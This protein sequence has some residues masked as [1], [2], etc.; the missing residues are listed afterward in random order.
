MVVKCVMS[1]TGK[2]QKQ[3]GRRDEANLSGA[4]LSCGAGQRTD[5]GARTLA[6]GENGSTIQHNK[7]VGQADILTEETWYWMEPLLNPLDPSGKEPFGKCISIDIIV[8][9][10]ELDRLDKSFTQSVLAV[11]KISWLKPCLQSNENILILRKKIHSC[12]VLLF[13]RLKSCFIKTA[14]SKTQA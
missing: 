4:D 6:I 9:K 11:C 8:W 2:C 1:I 10:F 13:E 3:A 14:V 12:L 7:K 5:K